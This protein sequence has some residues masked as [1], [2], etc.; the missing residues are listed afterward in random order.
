MDTLRMSDILHLNVG[1]TNYSTT[2]STISKYSDTM[3]AV[4]IQQEKEQRFIREGKEIFVDRDGFIFKYILEYLRNGDNV[5]LPDDK[6]TLRN[7][8]LEA[9]FYQISGLKELILDQK[10]LNSKF[11]I[12]DCVKLKKEYHNQYSTHSPSFEFCSIEHAS[13]Q[14][15]HH[16][17]NEIGVVLSV[18]KSCV[19]AKFHCSNGQHEVTCLLHL[20]Q[21]SLDKM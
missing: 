18:D 10:T 15:I 19:T 1:G 16:Y 14:P 5:V 11:N 8:L 20:P 3:L 12:G 7:L 9:D 17:R 6:S 4:M 2:V 13:N 21:D